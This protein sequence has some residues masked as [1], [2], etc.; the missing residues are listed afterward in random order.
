MKE[1]Q[2]YEIYDRLKNKYDRIYQI[3]IDAGGKTTKKQ[4]ALEIFIF[5]CPVLYLV[6]SKLFDSKESF[7]NFISLIPLVIMI[8]LLYWYIK[9]SN[10]KL[11]KPYVKNLGLKLKNAS[12]CY[13]F[14]K[15][16]IKNNIPFEDLKSVERVLSENITFA[17]SVSLTIILPILFTVITNLFSDTKSIMENIKFIIPLLFSIYVIIFIIANN[18]PIENKFFKK[19]IVYAEESYNMTDDSVRT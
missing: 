1:K 9:L 8:V 14:A 10:D 7:L 4:L 12:I 17:F 15:E 2:D 3:F 19:C 11:F 6:L 13:S 18:K 16:C 5:V